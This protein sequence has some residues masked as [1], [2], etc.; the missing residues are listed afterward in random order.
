MTAPTRDN[1]LTTTSRLNVDWVVLS[2]AGT[3]YSSILSYN[4]QWDKGT[5]GGVWTDLTGISSDYTSLSFAI[6]SEVVAGTTYL[7]RVRAKNYW[8]W[9][10]FSSTLSIKAAMAPA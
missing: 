8:G 9:G 6:T 1:T 7:I 5:N 3:G 2:T 10:P 4:L